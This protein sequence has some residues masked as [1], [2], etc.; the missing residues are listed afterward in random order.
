MFSTWSLWPEIA[1]SFCKDLMEQPVLLLHLQPMC[2]I[3]TGA[4]VPSLAPI[5]PSALVIQCQ[6][7]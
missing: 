5:L 3:E 4:E 1:S 2:C 6:G 7:L